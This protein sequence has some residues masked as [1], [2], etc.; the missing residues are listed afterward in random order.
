MRNRVSPIRLGGLAAVSLSGPIGD[1]GHTIGDGLTGDGPGEARIDTAR[2]L[3][4]IGLDIEEQAYLASGVENWT[5]AKRERVAARIRRKLA[6]VQLD[7]SAYTV[8][9]GDSRRLCFRERGGTWQLAPLG[10]GFLEIM[11]AERLQVVDYKPNVGLAVFCDS[12]SRRLIVL[13]NEQ[14]ADKLAAAEANVN[15]IRELAEAAEAEYRTALNAAA[16][17]RG[18]FSADEEEAVFGDRPV[19]PKLGKAVTVAEEDVTRMERRV[20]TIERARAKAADEVAAIRSEI[21]S[22]RH[23]AFLEALAPVRERFDA[24]LKAMIS[25]SDDVLKT[26]Q[27]YGQY[28]AIRAMWPDI[29]SPGPTERGYLGGI[30]HQSVRL[31]A[32]RRRLAAALDQEAVA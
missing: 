9:T 28:D 10:A 6:R 29:W 1:T 11:L 20:A 13:N 14:L 23:E 8:I 17:A 30:L 21:D 22:R 12:H 27:A 15:R 4:D 24:A 16:A 25:A 7:S 31:G 3:A 26:A 5:A 32:M 2:V 19:S 18:A